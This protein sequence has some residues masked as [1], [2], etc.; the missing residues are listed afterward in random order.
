[1]TKERF[2]EILKEYG[3]NDYQIDILWDSRPCD[4]LDEQE[5]RMAAQQ[6]APIKDSF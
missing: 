1:M 5:L 2:S 6:T 4:N 3:F